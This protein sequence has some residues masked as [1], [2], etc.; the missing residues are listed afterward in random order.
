[1]TFYF[2]IYLRNGA[3]II[4]ECRNWET[5]SVIM[6]IPS[7]I[8]R[9]IAASDIFTSNTGYKEICSCMFGEI[10]L[11]KVMV[12]NI[13]QHL[14]LKSMLM[15]PFCHLNVPCYYGMQRQ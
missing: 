1:V 14:I 6:I 5:F 4:S 10:Q 11:C 13:M 2:I 12:K 8:Q 7:E 9:K 3:V 15:L